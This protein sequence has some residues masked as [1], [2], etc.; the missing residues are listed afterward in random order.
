MS[1]HKRAGAH[2]LASLPLLAAVT[3]AGC[4]HAGQARGAQGPTAMNA[5]QG[6]VAITGAG[7]TFVYPLM[8]RWVGD[9][10]P[11]HPNVE[12]N[13]Q[14]IG[15][16]GG[17]QQVRV[18]TID[19]GASD[20]A[21]GPAELATMPAVVQIAE[22]AGPVC[23]T[24][25]LPGLRQPLRLSGTALASIYLGQIKNWDDP[26]IG[27]DNPHARL[28]HRPILVIHRAEGSGTTNIFTTYLSAVSPVWAKQVGHGLAVHWP[29][30]LGGEGS[31]GVTGL[32]QETPG[33]IGYTE[34]NYA[35]ANQLPVAA[36]QNALG[37]WV[38]PATATATADLHAAAARLSR[39][40]GAPAVNGR[41]KGAY[42]ITGL[43]FLI[44]PRH[45]Q[46][47]AERMALL[48]FLDW[49]LT[50]GQSIAAHLQYAPLPRAVVAL[51]MHRLALL[52]RA[53]P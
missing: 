48:Q 46:N 26:A 50:D 42:P 14:S 49:A 53:H 11:S 36:I 9:Y 32:V 8:S 43:T 15:S 2:F 52:R 20:I 31:E 7:S 18:G 37:E 39:D 19:F 47:R 41:G 1:C 30:G 3:L 17:I 45:A 13:Y 16:G 4:H 23:I 34:L 40:L 33:A 6:I 29:A 44:I 51:D 24:Y 21:L 10:R 28:P 5:T 25:N 27:R 12:I 22:S 35:V 38:L